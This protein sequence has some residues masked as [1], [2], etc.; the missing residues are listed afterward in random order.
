M[1]SQVVLLTFQVLL[2]R[3]FG[4]NEGQLGSILPNLV[5]FGSARQLGFV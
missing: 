3:W 2:L 4:A 5:N 1:S